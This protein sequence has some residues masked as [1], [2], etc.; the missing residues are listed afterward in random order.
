MIANDPAASDTTT[1]EAP[2]P[3]SLTGRGYVVLLKPA[4]AGSGVHDFTPEPLAESPVSGPGLLMYVD[5]ASSA[6][7]PYRELLYMPGRFRFGGE[8]RWSIT[9]IVVSTE[10]SVRAG[11][12]N[13]GIP[14]ELASFSATPLDD[15]G[16]RIEVRQDGQLLAD[17]EF[18]RAGIRLPGGGALLPRALRAMLQVQDGRCYRFA[19]TARGP[20]AWTRLRRLVTNGDRFPELGP[21]Q[22]LMACAAPN[23]ALGFPVASVSGTPGE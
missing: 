12:R 4:D 11:R 16:E 10:A 23:F 1:G 14:K 9:R 19:P 6:V 21:E 3:W 18:G 15:G 13:W 22:V 20:L 17:L 8:T 7:G 2:A 5:Y